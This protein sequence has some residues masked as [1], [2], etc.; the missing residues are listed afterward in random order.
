M[1]NAAS[2]LNSNIIDVS[3]G[4]GIIV[5]SVPLTLS[6]RTRPR[7]IPHKVFLTG[8]F[9]A[10]TT[11]VTGGGSITAGILIDGKLLVDTELGNLPDQTDAVLSLSGVFPVGAGAHVF[12]LQ[13]Y[14]FDMAS[15]S[16]HHRS[17]TAIDLEA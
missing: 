12:E 8:Q 7:G 15:A 2:G 17:L 13:A 1:S 6:G 10:F 3:P 11:G 5:A 4:P 16:V 14:V 9:A